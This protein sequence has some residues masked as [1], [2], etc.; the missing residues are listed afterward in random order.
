MSA[1][2]D[3]VM[4]F[5]STPG[6]WYSSAAMA[7]AFNN[8]NQSPWDPKAPLNWDKAFGADG[9]MQR[10]ATSLLVA[11]GMN[12]QLS[13]TTTFSQEE[14]SEI[15]SNS[16]NG[17]WPFYSSGGGSDVKT[18]VRFST[19]GALNLNIA[20]DPKIPI[21]IGCNVLPVAQFVGHATEAA[22]RLFELSKKK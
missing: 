15:Q 11:S 21:V 20:S 6:L 16:S 4:T 18:D 9:D 7:L 5:A 12:I 14:Q 10:F 8:P 19:S 13:A 22:Q 3:H 1:T 2:F 17:M